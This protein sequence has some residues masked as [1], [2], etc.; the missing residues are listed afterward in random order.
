M[1][2]KSSRRIGGA[3][4]TGTPWE[5]RREPALHDLKVG[6]AIHEIKAPPRVVTSEFA[7]GDPNATPGPSLSGVGF[8]V[9]DY[10]DA[11][12]A[13]VLSGTV[14]GG[15]PGDWYE[16]A[17]D[18]DGDGTPDWTGQVQTDPAGSW[19][20]AATLAYAGT[21]TITLSAYDPETG[22]ATPLPA[23]G[24]AFASAVGTPKNTVGTITGLE[25]VVDDSAGYGGYLR[26][27]IAD[28]TRRNSGYTI[29]F[30]LDG[31]KNENSEYTADRLGSYRSDAKAFGFHPT[32]VLH[33]YRP[34][35]AAFRVREARHQK[36]AS[37]PYLHPWRSG[38]FD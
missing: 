23:G 14:V 2:A 11:A 37:G 5:G 17:L 33:D 32:P 27:D 10:G 25:F 8:A 26:G 20:L 38:R 31:K 16:L 30:D 21:P 34:H 36:S 12:P 4:D 7:V 22:T 15:T 35:Q 28:D 3:R 24:Y 29:E 13:G 9:S 18:A 19:S 6:N 1:G